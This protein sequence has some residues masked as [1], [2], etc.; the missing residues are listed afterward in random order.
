MEKFWYLRSEYQ[1]RHNEI[2]PW[3][4]SEKVCR[5]NEKGVEPSTSLIYTFTNK[6]SREPLIENILVLERIMLL[7]IWHTMEV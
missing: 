5:Q 3:C 6:V 1:A 4:N 7:C 2:L